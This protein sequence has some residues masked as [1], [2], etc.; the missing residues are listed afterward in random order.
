M[1]RNRDG[2]TRISP[3]QTFFQ[4]SLLW[5][6]TQCTIEYTPEWTNLSNTPL[7]VV[8]RVKTKCS[9]KYG[10]SA[11]PRLV[12]IIAAVPPHY[13]RALVPKLKAKPIRTAS[14]VCVC[15]L[16]IDKHLTIE[17]KLK[18]TQGTCVLISLCPDC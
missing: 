13:R 1:G 11:Q 4:F 2:P 5:F 8:I 15:V 17:I 16:K 6:T 12:D 14:G 18:T 10:L 7:H 3:I 9:A